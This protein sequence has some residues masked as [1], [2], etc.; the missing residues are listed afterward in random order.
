MESVKLC[1]RTAAKVAMLS[2]LSDDLRRVIGSETSRAGLLTLFGMLQYP[3]LNK[4][5]LLVVLEGV[6]DTI[7]SEHD[8]PNLYSK[9]H[10]RSSRVRNELRNSQRTHADLRR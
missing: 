9:L 5:L 4:R 7:F 8:L 10:S 6:L 2:S 3:A 1:T